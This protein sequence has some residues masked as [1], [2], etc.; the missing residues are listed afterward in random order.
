M[1]AAASAFPNHSACPYKTS[2]LLLPCP[3]ALFFLQRLPRPLPLQTIFKLFFALIVLAIWHGIVLLPVL[4]SL[5]GPASY[6]LH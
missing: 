6:I 1:A 2:T 4:L 3:E 5:I